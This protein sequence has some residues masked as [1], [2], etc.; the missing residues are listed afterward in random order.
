[1]EWSN[2]CMQ[3]L[4]TMG[5]EALHVSF[6]IQKD[7]EQVIGPKK[8]RRTGRDAAR[9]AHVHDTVARKSWQPLRWKGRLAGAPAHDQPYVNV[10]LLLQVLQ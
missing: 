5:A 7:I 3:V 4:Q 6:V 2:V 1:M 10:L 9:V 8:A